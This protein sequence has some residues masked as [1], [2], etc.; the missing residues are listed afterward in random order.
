[1]CTKPGQTYL[2]PDHWVDTAGPAAFPRR[3]TQMY[4]DRVEHTREEIDD[5]VLTEV[6]EGQSHGDGIEH[7]QPPPRGSQSADDE[8]RDQGGERR[9]ER[10]HRRDRIGRHLTRAEQVPR[11]VDVQPQPAARRGPDNRLDDTFPRR[12]PGWRRGKEDIRHDTG[13]APA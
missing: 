6:D 12:A 7:D 13:D 2:E 9:V 11:M 5:V 10:G 4:R 3:D 8:Q 1:M